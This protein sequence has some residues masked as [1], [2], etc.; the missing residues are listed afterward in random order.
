MKK[1]ISVL[2][3]YT[4]SSVYRLVLLFVLMTAVELL[5]FYLSVERCISDGIIGLER[6]FGK[7]RIALVMAAA[8]V[9]MT[10]QLSITG[11]EYGSRQGYTLRRL[12][13]SE[14]SVYAWQAGFNTAMYFVF[15]GVQLMLTLAMAKYGTEKMGSLASNQNIFL[16]FYRNGFLHSLLPLAEWSRYLRNIAL[17]IAL[18]MA[19]ALF[20][21][22][23]RRKKPGIAILFMLPVTAL[24]F[25]G[26][27]GN[28]G[29]DA[30]QILAA[31]AVMAW[32]VYRVVSGEVADKHEE[33]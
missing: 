21:Y 31:L 22:N 8:F 1:H 33:V 24:P 32:C 27:T 19:S 14:K 15:W 29:A 4:R 20:S 28:G 23:Q 17:I 11:C 16:A 7:S 30:F 10:A 2:M 9:L 3:L 13:V 25:A 6:M 12:R 18:G 5:V 26:S